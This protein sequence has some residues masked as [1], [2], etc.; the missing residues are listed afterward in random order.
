MC[1]TYKEEL[2]EKLAQRLDL[3]ERGSALCDAE[4]ILTVSCHRM[5]MSSRRLEHSHT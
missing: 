2:R 4:A 3:I 5:I 1:V